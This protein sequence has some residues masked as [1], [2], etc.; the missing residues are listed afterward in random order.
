MPR[1]EENCPI[2]DP[3]DSWRQTAL[4]DITAGQAVVRVVGVGNR[5]R[6]T[7]IPLRGVRAATIVPT[8]AGRQV[9]LLSM[10]IAPQMMHP[11]QGRSL[12][13]AEHRQSNRQPRRSTRGT[14]HIHFLEPYGT[15]K[16]IGIGAVA[17]NCWIVVSRAITEVGPHRMGLVP[18]E[19][20]VFGHEGM[21]MVRSDS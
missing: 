19:P 1:L 9:M 10:V 17:V 13:G 3:D 14:E 4:G 2:V 6:M 7:V 18:R 15:T 20:W 21:V 11:P 5:G 8:V 12:N 16:S